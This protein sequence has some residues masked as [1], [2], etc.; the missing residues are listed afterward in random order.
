MDINWPGEKTVIKLIDLIDK[1]FSGA[2]T[3]YQI[4]RTGKATAETIA[5]ER[6]LLADVDQE[7]T[8]KARQ[9]FEAL[10]DHSEP[11][12]MIGS[13]AGGEGTNSPSS[14]ANGVTP[15]DAFSAFVKG[16]DTEARIAEDT[17]RVH[18]LLRG[19]RAVLH[20]IERLRDR[21]SE[22]TEG[23]QEVDPDWLNRWRQFAENTSDD[24]MLNV[25]G[26][27]LAGE[28]ETPGSIGIRAMSILNTMSRKEAEVIEKV[29][30]LRL[31]NQILT[32][33]KLHLEFDVQRAE[34][35]ELEGI[36]ILT[37]AS[38]G[39][40]VQT[41]WSLTKENHYCYNLGVDE[42]T[43]IQMIGGRSMIVGAPVYPLTTPGHQIM[44]LIHPNCETKVIEGLV[45]ELSNQ[46]IGITRQ[47]I[48]PIESGHIVILNE[49]ILKPLPDS[50]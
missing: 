36:G 31:Y 22:P 14:A 33:P 35:I 12:L 11:M 37:G 26:R 29:A 28:F 1:G 8:A 48:G 7:I 19:K 9:Q 30:Q 23:A 16:I 43:I 27:V 38:T 39:A 44:K 25:W 41:Q 46:P 24:A 13:D 40:G 21:G 17:D 15:E 49:E 34:L 5:Y 42:Q 10:E 2:L 4:R 20:A 45:E 18:R 3:P 32:R 50:S 47:L 6:K